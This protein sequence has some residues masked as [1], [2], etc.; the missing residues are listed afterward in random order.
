MLDMSKKLDVSEEGFGKNNSVF[1]W[2]TWCK[3]GCAGEID[4][5]LES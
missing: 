5:L 3:P 2:T 1:C 4:E